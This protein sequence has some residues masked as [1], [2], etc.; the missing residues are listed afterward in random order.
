LNA[1]TT[2]FYK[3]AYHIDQ[4]WSIAQNAARQKHIDQAISFNLY[5]TNAIKAKALLE[6]HLDAWKQGLKTTYYVRSTSKEI[7]ECDSCAS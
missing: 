3:S 4:H 6:L 2:W 7:E 5:V 1:S